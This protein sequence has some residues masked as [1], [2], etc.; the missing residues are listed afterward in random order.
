MKSLLLL[1]AMLA[2]APAAQAEGLMEWLDET[3][4]SAAGHKQGAKPAD[5]A[6]LLT[7]ESGQSEMFPQPS[8]DGR[9]LLTVTRQ[10]RAAWISRR[11]SENGDAANLVSE[12]ERALDSIGWINNSKVFYLSNRAGGLGVWEKIS[13]GEGMQRRIHRLKGLLLQPI[14]RS[15]ETMFA[16]RLV[17]K[18]GAK[19]RRQEHRD[20]FNNWDFPG[21]RTEIVRI[22]NN[23]DA[24]SLSEGVNPALSPD[25]RWLVFSIAEGRSVH[26][27]RMRTDGSELIQITDARSIDVQPSWSRDGRR[28]LFT[29]NRAGA[30]MRHPSHSSWDI[31]S[32]GID[33]RNLQQI[34]FDPARDGAARMGS[35]GRIYFHSDR[36]IAKA[37]RKQ[38]QVKS[39]K[40]HSFHIWTIAMPDKDQPK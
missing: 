29:S 26:L 39:V 5:A 17:H 20:P 18:R 19:P 36:P 6:E 28:I 4:Q 13:D 10:G 22:N 35:D 23:G 7:L 21:Y 33:G 27:Y 38:R 2:L 24:N 31:W 9:F 15:D 25:G 1:A 16:V 37:V 40:S 30:D 32:I 12:D 11:Y 14:L 34:T 8:P 3:L